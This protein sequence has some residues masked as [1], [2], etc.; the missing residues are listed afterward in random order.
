M[1]IEET[2]VKEVKDLKDAESY[3]LLNSVKVDENNEKHI[4]KEL[5]DA[6]TIAS[7]TDLIMLEE[8]NTKI[9]KLI[10]SII[11]RQNVLDKKIEEFKVKDNSSGDTNKL[12]NE[13]TNIIKNNIIE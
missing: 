11:E 5:L 3:I 1:K 10:K 8:Q 2:N 9:I 13:L 7:K 6:S 4:T 12:L